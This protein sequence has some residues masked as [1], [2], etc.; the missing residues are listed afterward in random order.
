MG[1]ILT[2]DLG[3]SKIAVGVLTDA[4]NLIR[5]LR[6]P[7]GNPRVV[8][9][10][11]VKEMI[12]GA[13]CE[14]VGDCGY[15]ADEVT[16]VTGNSFLADPNDS[17]FLKQLFPNADVKL[18][19]ESYLNAMLSL[20][21]RSGYTFHSGTG[22]YVTWFDG[23][24][25][26]YYGGFGRVFGDLG[27]GYEIGRQ[28][29]IA[30]VRAAEGLGPD[31]ALYGRLTELC[32]VDESLDF[33]PRMWELVYPS[34]IAPD[35]AAY[36]GRIAPVVTLAAEEGDAVA[37]GILRDSAN[38]LV[39]YCQVLIRKCDCPE[40]GLF[41]VSGG[42]LSG[43]KIY[44][45]CLREAVARRFPS[46]VFAGEGLSLWEA[47]YRCYVNPIEYRVHRDRFGLSF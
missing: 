29:L 12:V 23:T 17:S 38:S 35:P 8:G 27:S 19:C 36:F 10:A 6:F 20:K 2:V 3:G 33:F 37:L 5:E 43:S 1:C 14:A 44:L 16:A 13:L 18:F 11:R 4:G 22:A 42:V 34:A 15:A 24:S 31:T 7:G 46:L 25:C 9:E 21:G 47:C 30:A 40:Q 26:A 28:G 41:G 45:D 39:D 32:G